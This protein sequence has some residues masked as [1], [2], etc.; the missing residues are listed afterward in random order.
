MAFL[1]AYIDDSASHVGDQR[2]FMAGYLN[3]AEQ[4]A[5]F[6]EAWD[7]EL[8]AA[9]AIEYLKM[10]EA[11]NLRDQFTGWTPGGRDEKLRGLARVIRHFQ[12]FSFEFSVSRAQYSSIVKPASPRGLGNAHFVCCFGMVSSLARYADGAGVRMPIKFI[13]DQQD[14]VSTD[15]GLFFDR[16]TQS[17]PKSARKL[18]S[19]SPT[20]EDDKL[21]LPLQAADM[22]AWHV[23]RE[24]ED[25]VPPDT[26][27]M[28]DLLR[29]D[30]GHLTSEIPESVMKSWADQFDKLP[31]VP[32]L[33]S[34]RDWR[35]FKKEMTRLIS[36]GVDPSTT[37]HPRGMI[38]RLTSR[39]KALRGRFF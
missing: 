15:I 20:F 30:H 33:Q 17:L 8:R 28:A 10:A 4:W 37:G 23:R 25:C 39:V 9:P 35:D 24:H 19:G 3:R 27:P 32:L 21:V 34:K 38:A 29:N 11:Q 14:G 26:L 13:F 22:L 1:Y 18:I 31:G 12:P 7:E 6:S 2:L 36:L 16:M 5:L